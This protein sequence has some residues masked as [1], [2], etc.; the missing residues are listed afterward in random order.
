[1]VAARRAVARI[2]QVHPDE[3][4]IVLAHNPDTALYARHLKP[5]VMLSGHTHGGVVRMPFYGSP[6]KLL[7]IGKQFYAGLNRYGNFLHLYQ[8]RPGHV[9]A[10]NQDQL[11]P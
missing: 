10:A 5:G 11:P 1:M 7:R 8:S 6:L 9:L 4:T 2:S 3:C